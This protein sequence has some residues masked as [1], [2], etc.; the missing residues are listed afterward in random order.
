MFTVSAYSRDRR[1]IRFAEAQRYKDR[2]RA[3]L[4]SI[5]SAYSSHLLATINTAPV[6][7]VYGDYHEMP[8]NYTGAKR[9]AYLAALDRL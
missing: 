6:A 7:F 3:Q 2:P 1:T 9:A 4:A 5:R 8:W